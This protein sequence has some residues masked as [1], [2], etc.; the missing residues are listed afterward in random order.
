MR[1]FVSTITAMI[2]LLG[3]GSSAVAAPPDAPTPPITPAPATPATTP[4]P[5]TPMIQTEA[6]PALWMVKGVHG[7]VYLFGSVHVMKKEVHWETPQVKSAFAASDAL[8]LEIA[9]IDAASQAAAQP[10]VMKLGF[11]AAHPL[12]TKIS[13]EDVQLLDA[14]AKKFGQPGEKIFEPMQPWMVSTTLS[15][16]PALQSGYDPNSGVDVTLSAE[17]A[18]AKKPI[19]GFETIEGQLHLFAD[20]PMSEQV[21]MLHQELVDAPREAGQI[22]T[23]VADWSRGDVENIAALENDEMKTKYPRLYDRLLVKRNAGFTD[24]V[25]SLLQNPATGTI[26]V[27]VGV[28][29]LAGPDSVVKML[30]TQGYTVTRAE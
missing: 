30:E 9:G 17:A 15:L 6:T 5:A 24:G 8:Y 21:E 13:P 14:Q 23:I 3:M 12:S 2:A 26:F 22:D 4:A 18:A 16:L 27:A 28:A 1:N 7:T 29:H 11:D 10:L 19:K 25:V 20:A